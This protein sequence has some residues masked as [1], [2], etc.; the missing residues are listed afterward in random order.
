[1][2]DDIPVCD[3]RV[4]CVAVVS[5]MRPVRVF[6]LADAVHCAQLHF[7]ALRA[8]CLRFLVVQCS[9]PPL[10]AVSDWFNLLDRLI[11]ILW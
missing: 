2:I 7:P 9:P 5:Y 4:A 3:Q 10:C 8:S 11:L 1:M 6:T